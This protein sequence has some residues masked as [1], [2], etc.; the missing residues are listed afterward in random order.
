MYERVN[1][2]ESARKRDE[3]KE[4]GD[5]MQEIPPGLSRNKLNRKSFITAPRV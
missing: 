4:E 5:G 2:S 1:G 3:G